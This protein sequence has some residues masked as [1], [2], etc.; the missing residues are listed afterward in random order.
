MSTPFGM[1]FE[2]IKFFFHYTVINF[3]LKYSMN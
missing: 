2:I 3:L 1:D